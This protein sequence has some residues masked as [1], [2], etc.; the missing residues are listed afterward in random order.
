MEILN[1]KR[2]RETNKPMKSVGLK[3]GP[4]HDATG[5]AQQAKWLG[6]PMPMASACSAQSPCPRPGW[7]H[8]DQCGERMAPGNRTGS[9]SH[10]SGLST[11]AAGDE[12]ARRSSSRAAVLR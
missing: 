6:Q 8:A 1:G 2:I 7:W 12:V 10:L 11:V 3:F 4:R 9:G 5:S